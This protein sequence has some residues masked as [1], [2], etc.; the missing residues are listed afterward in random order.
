MMESVLSR[1]LPLVAYA[2]ENLTRARARTALAMAGITIGVVAIASLGMF[3]AAFE[4]STLNRVDDITRSVWLTPGEDAE[5]E[6]FS[7]DHV[8]MIE[9]STDSP[10]YTIKQQ[11]TGVTGLRATEQATVYGL[12]DPGAFVAAEDGRVPETWRSGAA[13]GP[14]LAETLDVGVGDSVT[15]DGETYR[16]VAVLESTSRSSLVR[17]DSAVVLPQSQVET[18]GYQ[19]A[20]IREDSPEAAFRT[21]DSLDAE[22]NGRKELYAVQDAEQ[23]IER[24]NQQMA[25][26]DTFLLGVGGVSMLVAA[27]SILNV[28]LMSTIERRGEIGVL[29]AVGY[30]RLDVLRLMLNEAMLLGVVGAV[31]GVGLSVLLGMAIN[32]QLLSD[33]LAFTAEALRYTV[34]GFVFGT[35]SSF[36]SGLYPAWKA[37]NARPVEALR[38]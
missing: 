28:M 31:L 18:D 37:A 30:H 35:A 4:Q 17:T 1:R 20:I 21:A 8:A 23:A 12:S 22:L 25:Q 27:V 16:V 14:D 29:R 38:D 32:A 13:V 5:F 6:E 26:I 15:V 33:P 7:R 9:R 2:W 3:G 34:V 10:V 24:F 19:S 11:S 36:L